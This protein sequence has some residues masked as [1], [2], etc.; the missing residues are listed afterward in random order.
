[1]IDDIFNVLYTSKMG[2][3]VPEAK[4]GD[5]LYGKKFYDAHSGEITTAT[6]NP[7]SIVTNKAQDSISTLLSYSPKQ[8]GSGDPS[9]SNVRPISGWTEANLLRSRNNIADS[10]IQ[11]SPIQSGSGD[12]SPTN[13]RPISAGLALEM[14]DHTTLTVYGGNLDPITGTLTITHDFAVFDGSENWLYYG[15]KRYYLNNAIEVNRNKQTTTGYA[16]NLYPFRGNGASSSSDVSVDKSVY[17]WNSYG[18]VWIYDNDIL[19]TNDL[20]TLLE[21]TPLQICYPLATPQEINLSS[22]ELQRALTALE[23]TTTTIYLGGTYSGFTVDVENGVLRVS[24]AIVDLGTLSWNVLGSGR[25]TANITG[26]KIISNE[27]TANAICTQYKVTYASGISSINYGFAIGLNNRSDII[28]ND[29]DL[30]G[31]SGAYFQTAMN[32]V[33]VAYELATP[34][35]LPL[36]PQTVALLAGNN[37]VWCDGDEL[38][39][40]YKAKKA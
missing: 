22:T 15:S 20:K 10:V 8:I 16:T 12:P 40:T 36:T 31:A 28:I 33:Y 25:H 27:Q 21:E 35:E 23:V 26:A 24:H 9:P 30:N 1:M 4:I 18:R 19:T 7:V 14:D 39:I 37:T 32:G 38:S 2:I 6:G 11:I 13:I 3:I 34:L 29:I 17:I 5:N